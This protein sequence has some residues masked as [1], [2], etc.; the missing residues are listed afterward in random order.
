MWSGPI[1]FYN[2]HSPQKVCQRTSPLPVACPR[3]TER[4]RPLW[5]YWKAKSWQKPLR[6][7][8]LRDF[9][10]SILLEYKLYSIPFIF[11]TFYMDEYWYCM[12]S[13]T[14]LAAWILNDDI[15]EKPVQPIHFASINY[16]E[17]HVH[18]A[19]SNMTVYPFACSS[20]KCKPLVLSFWGFWHIAVMWQKAR[21]KCGILER[22]V[23]GRLRIRLP[24]W[25]WQLSYGCWHVQ[26]SYNLGKNAIY[27]SYCGQ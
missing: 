3:I 6:D 25:W 15:L 21:M 14:W 4:S 7:L 16:R 1:L 5:S 17:S 13:Q 20:V 27:I 26:S 8:L 9:I 11:K 22:S 10:Y 18:L 12:W 2:C 24:S 23:H 19:S